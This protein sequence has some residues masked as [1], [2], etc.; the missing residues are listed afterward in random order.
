M[1]GTAYMST[2]ASRRWLRDVSNGLLD[3]DF[4]P[5]QPV[6]MVVDGRHPL[7]DRAATGSPVST[8]V[9]IIEQ[10]SVQAFGVALDDLGGTL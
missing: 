1:K 2:P 3:L 7:S 4:D 5:S 10:Y 8:A 6:R 9:D